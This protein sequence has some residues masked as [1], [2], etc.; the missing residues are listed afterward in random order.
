MH[1]KKAKVTD[2][3]GI[4]TLG[5]NAGHFVAG[6]TDGIGN[7]AIIKNA[8]W[9]IENVDAII[10]WLDASGI[11]A[12]YKHQGMVLTFESKDDLAMFLVRWA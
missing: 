10:E 6:S 1:S 3:M 2:R 7:Y 8:S 4:V 9:W 12:R 5:D 11:G